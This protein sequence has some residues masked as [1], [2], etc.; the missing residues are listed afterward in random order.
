MNLGMVFGSNDILTILILIIHEHGI[1]FK[2]GGNSTCRQRTE[3]SYAGGRHVNGFNH[4]ENHWQL[5]YD[6][7]IPFLEKC[8][9]IFLKGHVPA[10]LYQFY[11]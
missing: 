8:R 5:P 9:L 7:V 2:V 10:Y 3:V 11:P 4:L 6:S 1:D